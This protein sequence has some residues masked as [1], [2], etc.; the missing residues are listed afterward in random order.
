[1]RHVVVME[2]CVWFFWLIW[3]Q[4]VKVMNS[5]RF[6][7][8][9]VIVSDVEKIRNVFCLLRTF[10]LLAYIYFSLSSLWIIKI[11]I[12]K[13]KKIFNSR[14]NSIESFLRPQN[15]SISIKTWCAKGPFRPHFNLNRTICKLAKGSQT[16]YLAITHPYYSII[17][18]PKSHG[19]LI[20]L[21]VY[22]DQQRCMLFA[23][24]IL[25]AALSYKSIYL[26]YT[27]YQRFRPQRKQHW[28][29]FDIQFGTTHDALYT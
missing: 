3:F 21:L 26:Q 15:I 9:V 8:M 20:N 25:T 10:F 27:I 13:K 24:N 22:A 28:S 2:Y 16:A 6:I 12:L 23:N 14:C 18:Q 11:W 17:T 29:G 1:M 19:K 4:M 5:I 7:S